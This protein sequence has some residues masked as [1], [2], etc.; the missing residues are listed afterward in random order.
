MSAWIS[1]WNGSFVPDDQVSISPSDRGFIL[2]DA[3]YEATRTYQHRPF[4]LDW[5]FDRLFLSLEYLRLDPGIDRSSMETLTESVLKRNNSNLRAHDDVSIVHRVTRG[6]Y[7]APYSDDPPGPP[8][9]LITCRPIAFTRF[10]DLYNHGVE[11]IIPSVKSPAV[12]GID[13]R[14]KTQSRLLLALGGVEAQARGRDVLALF[15]DVDGHVTESSSSNVF[16]VFGQT[17]ATANDEAVLG[18]ITRKVIL[19]LAEGLGLEAQRR[20]IHQ[21][22]LVEASEAFVTA[23]SIGILPVRRLKGRDLRLPGPITQRLTAAFNQYVGLN[24]VEQARSHLREAA[25][26]HP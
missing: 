17:L 19:R 12:G 7:R 24:I 16:F 26:P 2:G 1:Y 4:H 25:S 22:E 21:S 8:T 6:L 11:L 10:A 14:I 3:V 15:S 5:H 20:P 9:L 23:T 18:G 13:P